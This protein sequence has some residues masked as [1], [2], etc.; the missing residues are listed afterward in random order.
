MILEIPTVSIL[1]LKHF[2]G[3]PEK[4]L[5]TKL[6]GIKVTFG[7]GSPIEIPDFARAAM[8]PEPAMLPIMAVGTSRK[9]CKCSRPALLTRCLSNKIWKRPIKHGMYQRLIWTAK[10]IDITENFSSRSRKDRTQWHIFVGKEWVGQSR[11]RVGNKNSSIIIRAHPLWLSLMWLCW[12]PCLVMDSLMS[13]NL[14]T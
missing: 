3:N 2:K 12:T 10:A 5:Y 4:A 6:I 13:A 8:F 7:D 1:V 11:L 9:D 14:I